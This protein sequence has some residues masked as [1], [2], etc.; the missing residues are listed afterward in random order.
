MSAGVPLPK[1]VIVHGFIQGSDGRKMSKSIGNVVDAHNEL[2]LVSVDTFRW[3]LCR[4]A[5]YG[6]DIKYSR[7]SMRLMH[8]SELC[9]NLGN[10]VNRAVKM[11]GG[12][13]PAADTSLVK[14]PEGCKVGDRV[15]PEGCD[16][17]WPPA[18]SSV[19]AKKKIWDAVAKDLKTDGKKIACTAGVALVLPNGQKVEAPSLSDSP[20]S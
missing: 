18:S 4:E 19:V 9:D 14:F 6:D 16:T 17:K 15:L 3:Y 1:S 7:E 2:D 5:A 13:V 12:S 20:I 8:N 10:L 11:C